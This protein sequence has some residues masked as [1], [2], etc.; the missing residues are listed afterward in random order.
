MKWWT[1]IRTALFGEAEK[2][3]KK[4]RVRRQR[5]TRAQ[6]SF[7]N[8]L[9][10]SR[11]LELLAQQEPQTVAMLSEKMPGCTTVSQA[12]PQMWKRG[13]VHRRR[14]DGRNAYWYARSADAFAPQVV[15]RVFTMD[16][17]ARRTNWDRMLAHADEDV[18][19]AA[20]APGQQQQ[21]SAE[22]W[23]HRE[24]KDET[25]AGAVCGTEEGSGH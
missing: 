20:E 22:D 6:S 19:Q 17:R 4:P 15:E 14:E 3:P 7:A 8:S 5:P 21:A 2:P 12:L 18:S 16:E 1:R 13:V 25:T 10:E 24:C 9:T 11:L 23:S